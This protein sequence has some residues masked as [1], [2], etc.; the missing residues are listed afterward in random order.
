MEQILSNPLALKLIAVFVFLFGL[1]WGSFLNVC[2][3]RIPINKSVVFPPSS[4]PNCGHGIKWYENIP[5]LSYLFL[6]GKCSGCK[7]PI[8]PIYPIIEFIVGFLFLQAFIVY[9]F[10]IDLLFIFF[11]IS[12]LVTIAMIDYQ[13]QIVPDRISVTGIVISLLYGFIGSEMTFKSSLI[14]VLAG[15][16]GLIL[17]ILVFYLITK[18][19][20]MGGGDV[21]ILAMEGGFLGAAMLPAL[22]LLAAT[23]AIAAFFIARALG[24][25]NLAPNVT[26]EDIMS[27][28]EKD[29]ERVLPFGPFLALAGIILIFADKAK[30]L[31]FFVF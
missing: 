12:A 21:K 8:S 25:K 7:N 26:K 23:S 2:I 3:Y 9:G 20:G 31:S 1:C 18:K 30:V 16:G 29:L 10:T 11:Y 5:V 19:I 4:C 22:L 14:G 28:E 24:K 15:G 6:R 27:S 17:V 13:T